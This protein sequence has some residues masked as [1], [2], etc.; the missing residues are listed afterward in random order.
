MENEDHRAG[1]ILII[2]D[3]VRLCQLIGEFF[4]ESD[5]TIQ[6]VHNGTAGLACALDGRFDLILLDIMLPGLDGFEVLTQLRRRSSVPV[7]VLTA[8]GAQKDCVRG[9]DTGADDYLAKPFGPEE[10]AARMAAVLR[11]TQNSQTAKSETI[12][13]GRLRLSAASRSAWIGEESVEMTST[14]FDILDLLARARGK[15]VTRD[16]VCGILYQRQAT[17]FERSLEVHISRMRRKIEGAGVTIRSIRSVG[18]I[19]AEDE[20]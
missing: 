17:P 8:R 18:Y 4:S 12:S 2:D 1:N 15:V 7:I 20:S 3:D 19:L 10:L 11:R 5:Y 6:A 14:E 16:Q 9:L 13:V